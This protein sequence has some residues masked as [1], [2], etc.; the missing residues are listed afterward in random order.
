LQIR[1]SLYYSTENQNSI[2]SLFEHIIP[3]WS[4]VCFDWVDQVKGKGTMAM[5]THNA[6]WE[7]VR[8]SKEEQIKN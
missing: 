4:E 1:L 2:K 8:Q 7:E 5:F 3:V 6:D